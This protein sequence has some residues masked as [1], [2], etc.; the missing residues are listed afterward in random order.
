MKN[1]N[2]KIT[3]DTNLGISQLSNPPFK[4]KF[5]NT[6]DLGHTTFLGSFKKAMSFSDKTIRMFDIENR[7]E[8]RTTTSYPFTPSP[9]NFT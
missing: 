1:K 3:T 6:G 7:W 8:Q 9:I 4:F 5:E 2:S